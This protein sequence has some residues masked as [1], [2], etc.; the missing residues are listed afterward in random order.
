MINH[1]GHGYTEA[2]V[3][4]ENP[5]FEEGI[6]LKGHEFHYSEICNYD[7][8]IKSSLSV[9]RG[10]GSIGR[11]DG[12][13]YKN[14]F[15]TYIHVHALASREWVSGMIKAAKTYNDIKNSKI[16]LEDET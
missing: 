13:I 1:A 16:L 6:T 3:D 14:V 5:F 8:W 9:V 4:K 10:T 2:L 7:P 12:L 15:A 11:R